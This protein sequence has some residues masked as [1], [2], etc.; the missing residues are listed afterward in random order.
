MSSISSP[1]IS[2]RRFLELLAG[3]GAAAAAGEVFIPGAKQI[4]LP[5]AMGWPLR[6]DFIV[7]MP[8]LA[9]MVLHR[10]GLQWASVGTPKDR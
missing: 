9:G 3:A 5:P 2:R 8:A 1:M 10:V 4:F 7:E 6:Q